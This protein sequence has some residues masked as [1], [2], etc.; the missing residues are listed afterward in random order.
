MNRAILETH[1]RKLNTLEEVYAVPDVERTSTW[2]PIHHR[3][4]DQHLRDAMDHS[5]YEVMSAQYSLSSNGMRLFG[6]YI[7]EQGNDGEKTFSLGYRNA[8]DKSMS[9]AIGAGTYMFNCTNLAFSADF[10]RFRKHTGKLTVEELRDISFEAVGAVGPK[11]VDFAQWQDSLQDVPLITDN[12]ESLTFRAIQHGVLPAGRF[13]VL[14]K[15]YFEG[16]GRQIY[17]PNLLGFHGAMTE[18]FNNNSMLG[19]QERNHKL[20]ALMN[21]AV[22]DIDQ[23]GMI[24]N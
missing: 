11:F 4:L 5:G 21:G 10:V 17:E 7:L 8:M 20:N 14:Y 12:A 22:I 23:Y 19:M 2:N 1:G 16:E 9:I 18:T 6:I 24:T 3:V 15:I 13:S